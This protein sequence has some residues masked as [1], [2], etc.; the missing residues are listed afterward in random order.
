M[1]V[2][3]LKRV[4]QVPKAVQLCGRQR[5]RDREILRGLDHGRQDLAPLLH[6][7]CRQ[8]ALLDVAEDLASKRPSIF[9]A[10]C[11]AESLKEIMHG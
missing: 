9:K 11:L 1:V 3:K 7:V 8:V 6:E 10:P 2:Q 5:G 4:I